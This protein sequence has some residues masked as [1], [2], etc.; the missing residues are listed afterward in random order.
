MKQQCSQRK[1]EHAALPESLKLF[2]LAQCKDWCSRGDVRQGASETPRRRTGHEPLA[3]AYQQETEVIE[4]CE[5][6]CMSRKACEC[7]YD[8]S[9]PYTHT[10]THI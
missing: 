6:Y 7:A 3:L 1:G 8:N 9:P 5:G 10:H 4:K 2:C